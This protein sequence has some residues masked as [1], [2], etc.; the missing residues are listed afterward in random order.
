[1]EVR[2]ARLETLITSMAT[3]VKFIRSGPR[4]AND[5]KDGQSYGSNVNLGFFCGVSLSQLV[6]PYETM[7]HISKDY[8]SCVI[9]NGNHVMVPNRSEMI[10]TSALVAKANGQVLEPRGVD[11]RLDP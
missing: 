8:E 4:K 7:L 6:A 3:H 10:S 2:F 9:D 11:E 1:M 5:R